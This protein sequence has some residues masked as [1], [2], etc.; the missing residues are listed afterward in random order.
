MF[1]LLQELQKN[2]HF[3]SQ[4]IIK[5]GEG[6]AKPTSY[7]EVSVHYVGRFLD[8]TEFDSSRTQNKLLTLKLDDNRMIKGWDICVATMK[9]GEICRLV[10]SPEHGYGKKGQPP[11]IP[12]D[13]LLVFEIELVSWHGK[14]CL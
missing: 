12:G 6:E 7:D 3:Y 5:E 4:V 1:G 13:A 9:A 8:G 2:F 11:K 14:I 10:C